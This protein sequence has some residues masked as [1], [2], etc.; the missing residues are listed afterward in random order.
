MYRK[1]YVSTQR[2][3]CA[4]SKKKKTTLFILKHCVKDILLI[5]FDNSQMLGVER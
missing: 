4:L 2:S 5:K 3:T 1:I